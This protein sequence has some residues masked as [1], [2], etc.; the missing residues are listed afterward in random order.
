MAYAGGV[1][2]AATLPATREALRG[3]VRRA[4][5]PIVVG[6]AL[7]IGGGGILEA[8]GYRADHETPAATAGG[9]IAT[10]A[11]SRCSSV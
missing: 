1:E 4:V 2:A 11:S 6:L 8:A 7:A 9:I 10:A 3:R 5:S